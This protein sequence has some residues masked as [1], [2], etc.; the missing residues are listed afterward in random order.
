MPSGGF[1]TKC[2]NWL[3][4]R[5]LIQSRLELVVG[6]VERPGTRPPGHHH[7]RCGENISRYQ[8]FQHGHPPQ[9]HHIPR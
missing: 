7:C 8:R 5:R 1:V 6:T 2:N 9:L 4:S 3:R